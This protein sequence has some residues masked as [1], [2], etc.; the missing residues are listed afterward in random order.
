MI[1]VLLA[2]LDFRR[3]ATLNNLTRIHYD[4]FC[5]CAADLS[6]GRGDAVVFVLDVSNSSGDPAKTANRISFMNRLILILPVLVLN[7][8]CSFVGIRSGTEQ[9]HYEVLDV[10]SKHVEIRR[11][12]SRLA[13]ETTVKGGDGRKARSEAFRRLFNY[14]SGANKPGS[15]VI[16][17]TE[18]EE[19]HDAGK[20]GVKI[21]MTAPVEM[22]VSQD[23]TLMRFFLPKDL[24]TNTAPRPKDH[25]VNVITVP[26]Q[27]LAVL[28]FTG[29][30][31]GG[32][33]EVQQKRLAVTLASSSHWQA[34]DTV[35]EY[36]YDPP[37][38]LPFMRRNEIVAVVVGGEK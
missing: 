21:A 6:F 32:D 16:M 33:L 12:G 38:T 27:T 4:S 36:Y 31:S 28:T 1:N 20:P 8:S 29:S 34:Q 26:E 3:H 24:S 25:R 37:W 19:V 10:L 17:T 30:A 35:T 7:L 13:V 9:P 14:I 5:L 15:T 23:F 18:R 2:A 11:Y 22:A